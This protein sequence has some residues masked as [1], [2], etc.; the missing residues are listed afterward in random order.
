MRFFVAGF[1]FVLATMVPIPQSGGRVLGVM[2]AGTLVTV[3][4]VDGATMVIG[5]VIADSE[6]PAEVSA[7]RGNCSQ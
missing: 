4:I 1:F 3:V 5:I 6:E 7:V 2:A